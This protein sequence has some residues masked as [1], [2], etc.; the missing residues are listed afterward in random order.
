M[1]L[2][3]TLKMGRIVASENNTKK[4]TLWAKFSLELK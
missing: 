4:L 3:T 1:V 2:D